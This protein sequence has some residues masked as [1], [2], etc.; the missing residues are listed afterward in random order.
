M[1]GNRAGAVAGM[2]RKNGPTGKLTE[3]APYRDIQK[4]VGDLAY[5]HGLLT[6]GG[7]NTLWAD[8]HAHAE[9]NLC[10]GHRLDALGWTCGREVQR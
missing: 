6:S 7:C 9:G 5:R 8:R 10:A 1:N 2:S 3:I 4:A